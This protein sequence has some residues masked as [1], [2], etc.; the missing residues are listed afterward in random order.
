MSKRGNCVHWPEKHF[1]LFFATSIIYQCSFQ[2]LY[3]QRINTSILNNSC[4]KYFQV[5]APEAISKLLHKPNLYDHPPPKSSVSSTSN[6]LSHLEKAITRNTKSAQRALPK[7]SS[8]RRL[9]EA[10]CSLSSLTLIRSF[11]GRAFVIFI[12]EGSP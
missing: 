12:Q 4:V 7:K 5:L 8:A 3:E 6:S 1:T 9:P 2:Q 11:S 10:H